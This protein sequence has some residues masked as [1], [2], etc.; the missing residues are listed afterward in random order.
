[1]AKHFKTRRKLRNDI[2]IKY[3]L[4]I[5]L[6][7]LVIKICFLLTLNTP[8]IDLVFTHNSLGKYHTYISN[9]TINKPHYFLSYYHQIY[10]DN[11]EIL[12]SYITNDKPLVYIYNTHQTEGYKDKKNVLNAALDLKE[13]LLK[14]NV[15]V[16]V[17]EGDIPEFMRTNNI[18]YNYSYYASKFYVQ[19]I[20]A[21]YQVDL[22]IDLHR[23]AVSKS[24]TTVTINKKKY[25]K[26]MFVIGKDHKNYKVNYEL[27]KKINKRIEK[28]YPTL[29]RGISLKSGN[30]VNGIYN[31]DLSNESILIELGGNKNTYEEV[32]NTIGVLAKILG[33]Y[34]YEE[35]KSV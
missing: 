20:L 25:A 6:S 9:E 31:Q 15:D 32:Q 26:I 5:L 28:D 18:S 12:A 1:M 30:G 19:D 3:L 21:K 2:I 10:Q 13:A 24:A 14:Y 11:N 33:D 17:E 29:T 27:A 16:I 22:L 23:D 34:L 8:I 4:I 7:Y 35:R